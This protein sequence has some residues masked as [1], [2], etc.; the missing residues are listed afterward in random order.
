MHSENGTRFHCKIIPNFMNLVTRSAI[1]GLGIGMA[2]MIFQQTTATFA[3]VNYSVMTFTKAGASINPHIS[4][5]ILAVVLIIGSFSATYLADKLGRKALLM[6][7]LLGCACGLLI[8]ALY[9][10]LSIKGFDLSSFEF[11][12]V[13][14]L[15]FV[16]FVSAAGIG[17]LSIICRYICI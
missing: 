13:A 4:S 16:I 3:I 14:S 11:L 2:L 15:C 9:H 12:P 17:P 5:V 10:Y 7:S 1:K 6:G 8:T